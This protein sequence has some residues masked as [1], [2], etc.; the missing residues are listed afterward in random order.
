MLEAAILIGLAGWR[1]ASLLIAEDGPF[2]VFVK[3]RELAIPIGEI[4]PRPGFFETLFTCIWCMSVWTTL[5]MALTWLF[6]PEAVVVIAA[7]SIALIPE[8]VSNLRSH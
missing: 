8:L 5:L 2:R 1:I 6:V 7:M 3:L 4:K